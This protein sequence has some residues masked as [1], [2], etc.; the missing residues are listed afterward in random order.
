LATSIADARALA[1]LHLAVARLEGLRGCCVEAFRQLELARR[2]CQRSADPQLTCSLELVEAS[3]ETLAGNFAR[4]LQMSTSCL[5]RATANGLPRF[6]VSASA[7]LALQHVHLLKLD[8]ARRHIDGILQ[9]SPQISYV[10]LAVLDNLA[11]VELAEGHFGLAQEALDQCAEVAEGHQVPARS[12]NDLASDL[13]RA[14]LKEQLEDWEG[15][16]DISRSIDDELERRHYR[17]L[18]AS[19][20]S[21]EARALSM[22]SEHAQA[23]IALSKASLACPKGAVEPLILLELSRAICLYLGRDSTSSLVHL[24]RAV[25]AARAIGHK[26]HEFA[27]EKHWTLV[28][29][30][31]LEHAACAPVRDCSPADVEM[32]LSDVATVLAAGHS[33]DLLAQR[34]AGIL[35]HAGFASRLSLVT[36][37]DVEFAPMPTS[38]GRAVNGNFQISIHCSDRLV[39]I[40]VSDV[41]SLDELSILWNLADVVDAAVKATADAGSRDGGALWPAGGSPINE[42]VVFRSPRMLEVLRVASRLAMTDIP[43]LITGETGTGK[44]IVARLIHEQSRVAKGPFVPFNCSAIPKELVESQLFGHRRGA[45]TGAVDSFPGVIR[46]AD[47]GT[48]FL[49]EIGDLDLAVQPK[50]LRFL[51]SGEIHPVG[52]VKARHVS[53]RIVAATNSDLEALTAEGRFRSDL[54]YRIGVATVSLPPLR[55]RKDEIPS[56]ASL[57]LDRFSLE[58]GRR[59]ILLSDEFIAALLM[60]DWPGNIRQLANEIRRAVA[61]AVDGQTLGSRDLAPAIAEGWNNRPADA[62][63]PIGPGVTV[64][65]NQPL[66]NA[67]AELE[68]KFIEHALE[69]TGG[70]VSDAAT[71]LG[72]SRKG[73]FLKRRR[74]G[75]ATAA[76]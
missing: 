10:R 74:R 70:R 44:E 50:L 67:V 53:V 65:L 11:Q 40:T 38:E 26:H 61:M 27:I 47:R 17:A 19:M 45:F 33:V 29:Q 24:D 73:L 21:A 7:N 16:I 9:T 15:V 37:A 14:A 60:Y 43:V 34:V 2:L 63:A 71:L 6:A 18:R 51:E 48:L 59:G 23:E 49:D 54:F 57:F 36:T 3:L 62:T 46:A 31:R 72:L 12:W 42:D 76:D 30:G 68:Q 66:A 64:G 58:C 28:T 75:L 55:E 69:A 32:L 4:A 35:R 20:L 1:N 8:Y 22:L 5:N 41:T 13:T 52:E 39:V 25:T 56:L